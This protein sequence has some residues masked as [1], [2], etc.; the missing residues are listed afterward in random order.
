MATKNEGQVSKDKD[1]LMEVR[2]I[3]D[4][5]LDSGSTNYTAALDDISQVISGEKDSNIM[6]E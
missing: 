1:T 3:I 5:L 2:G 4:G 6:E